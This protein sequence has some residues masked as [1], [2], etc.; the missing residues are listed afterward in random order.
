MLAEVCKTWREGHDP[1]TSSEPVYA[2]LLR[3][4]VRRHHF[5]EL[6]A[7]L[8]SHHYPSQDLVVAFKLYS[9]NYMTKASAAHF[10]VHE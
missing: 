8:A 1:T 5:V 7:R 6:I 10:R 2:E 3:S 4:Q 9:H